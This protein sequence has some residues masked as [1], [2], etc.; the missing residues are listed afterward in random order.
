MMSPWGARGIVPGADEA[1]QGLTTRATM[2][3][4]QTPDRNRS[5][6]VLISTGSFTDVRLPA[7]PAVSRNLAD[8]RRTLTSDRGMFEASRVHLLD[9][10]DHTHLTT[11]GRLT[12]AT[13]D[14]LLV[15]YSG[16]GLNENDDLYLAYTNTDRDEPQLT[17]LPY[18]TLRYLVTASPARRC[19]VILDCCFSGKVIEWMS[20]DQTPTGELDIQGTYILT[21][22]GT[23]QKAIAPIGERH[24][25]FTGALL[26]LLGDGLDKATSSSAWQ[27]S[28]RAWRPI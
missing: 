4:V 16:H 3:V 18:Q 23:S 1:P 26:R 8:L 24:T 11:I 25:A 28:I 14:T 13:D 15:Y 20:G 5:T 7:L 17:A 9:Q 21:A 27:T 2:S 22:T 10:A 19:I 12:R 6:A